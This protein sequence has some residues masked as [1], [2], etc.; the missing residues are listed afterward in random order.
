MMAT[1]VFNELKNSWRCLPL[2]EFWEKI[3]FQACLVG[4]GLK[5]IPHWNAHWSSQCSSLHLKHHYREWY[6]KGKCHQQ[7]ISVFDAKL[8]GKLSRYRLL[9]LKNS[10]SQVY[11]FKVIF[12]KINIRQSIIALRQ[13]KWGNFTVVFSHRALLRQNRI[14]QFNFLFEISDRSTFLKD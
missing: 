6:K 4:S 3:N 1:L 11:A 8:S 12:C 9:I 7:I 2:H 5:L 10:N 13:K 14:L